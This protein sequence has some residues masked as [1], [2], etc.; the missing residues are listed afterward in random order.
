[1][2]GGERQ[3]GHPLDPGVGIIPVLH[4]AFRL[5]ALVRYPV[6][7]LVGA[8]ADQLAGLGPLLAELADGFLVDRHEGA[9][10]Y[11]LQ[12]VGDRP[13]QRHF[14]DLLALGF[15]PQSVE[16]ERAGVDGLGIVDAGCQ[17]Q[18]GRGEA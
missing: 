15:H 4:V 7:Q 5:D 14:Q 16:I 1:M 18:A 8:V 9:L 12:E 10:A 13:L 6:H 17:Q 2:L 3:I 11:Q